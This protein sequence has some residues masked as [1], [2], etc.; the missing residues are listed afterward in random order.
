MNILVPQGIGDS[1]WA[2][3]KVQDLVKKRGGG[4]LHLKVACAAD[5]GVEARAL[6]FLSRFDFVDSVSMYPMQTEP[7]AAGIILLPGPPYDE[8][9]YYRYIPDGPTFLAGIDYV[10]MPNAALERGIRL[11]QWLPEL[12][13]NWDVT[14]RFRF[15]FEEEMYGEAL[16]ER[17]GGYVIFQMGSAAA[18]TYAGHNRGPLWHPGDWHALGLEIEKRFGLKIVMVGA[19]YDR[20]YV[21]TILHPPASWIDLVGK[22]SI[23]KTFA[24]V[25][26]ARFAVTYQ[27]GI[28]I[29]ASYFGVP[30]AIFWRPK[31]DSVSPDFYASFE[32]SMASAWVRP[33]ML[34]LGKHLP[35]IYTKCHVTGILEEIERRGWA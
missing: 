3:H 25:K 20:D 28:G 26:R 9:G 34:S 5:G 12:H 24:V 10:M 1:I 35:L 27:S 31:G 22:C 29:L 13:T 7:G 6:E 11:E 17:L 23:G 33:D 4:P 14:R 8:A 32:E 16:K 2:L 18:N 21:E 15:L 30:T 19:E